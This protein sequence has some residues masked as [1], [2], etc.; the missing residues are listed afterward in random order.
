MPY[1]VSVRVDCMHS[2]SLFVNVETHMH[3]GCCQLR[4]VS[5]F[6]WAYD[7]TCAILYICNWPYVCL[8]VGT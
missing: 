3:L 6:D 4:V 5:W 7:V 2:F 8:S 1:H